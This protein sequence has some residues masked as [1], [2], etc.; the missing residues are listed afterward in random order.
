MNIELICDRIIKQKKEPSLREVHANMKVARVLKTKFITHGS[1]Q[2]K[3]ALTG[4]IGSML[5]H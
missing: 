5:L 4:D 3:R 2:M 1:V